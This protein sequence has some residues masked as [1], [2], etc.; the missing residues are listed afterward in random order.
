MPDPTIAG[1]QVTE[2]LVQTEIGRE[3]QEVE[4]ELSPVEI[5]KGKIRERALREAGLFFGKVELKTKEIL[6]KKT[7]KLETILNNSASKSDISVELIKTELELDKD[8]PVN[9][10]ICQVIKRTLERFSPKGPLDPNLEALKNELTDATNQETNLK[11]EYM[12]TTEDSWFKT[13]EG[14]RVLARIEA[15]YAAGQEQ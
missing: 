6:N 13:A 14:E 15:E 1:Q 4:R 11:K 7:A 9:E 2:Q 8:D 10:Y 12:G 3:S 5:K